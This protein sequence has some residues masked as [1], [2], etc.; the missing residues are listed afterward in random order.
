MR[1]C[2]YNANPLGR[3]VND[4]TVRAIALATQKSWD[5]AYD[6]LSLYA[7]AQGIMMDEVEYIDEYLEKNFKK[8]CGCK[9][10]VKVTVA[11]FVETHPQGTYLITMNGHITCCV[12]GCVYDTFNPEDR[13]I[14]GVY[15]V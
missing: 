10:Q 6:C 13:I 9:N 8:L 5:E 1:F 4:C 7:K 12:D 14:W 2:Y 11:Q 3:K 15:E